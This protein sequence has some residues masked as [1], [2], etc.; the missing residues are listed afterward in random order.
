[1]FYHYFLSI[2]FRCHFQALSCIWARFYSSLLKCRALGSSNLMNFVVGLLSFKFILDESCNCFGSDIS[3]ALVRIKV[4]LGKMPQRS[5]FWMHVS[6]FRSNTG[7][8][9]W[10]PTLYALSWMMVL[11]SAILFMP[12]YSVFLPFCH[13]TIPLFCIPCFDDSRA[14]EAILIHK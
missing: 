9:S 8:L 4:F 2:C 11:L 5:C 14:L 6:L 3:F 12:A 1:M 7:N 13:S 10:H